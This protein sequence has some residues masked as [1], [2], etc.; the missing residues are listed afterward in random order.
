MINC[1]SLLK[2]FHLVYATFS[3]LSV[4]EYGFVMF[5]IVFHVLNVIIGISLKNFVNFYVSF[6]VYVKVAHFV[7]W[8]CGLVFSFCSY[9]VG[10]FLIQHMLYVFIILYNI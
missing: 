6:P 10:C 8:C 4:C 5:C 9:V 3:Y 2:A 1:V 7:F